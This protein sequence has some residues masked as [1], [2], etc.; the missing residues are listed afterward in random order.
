MKIKYIG[1]YIEQLSSGS[2]DDIVKFEIDDIKKNSELFRLLN[3]KDRDVLYLIFV[4]NK[5]QKAVQEIL[6]RSQPLLCYD[7]KRIKER[8]RFIAYLRSVF[9]ILIDFIE[10]DYEKLLAETEDLEK[11]TIDILISMFFTTSYTHTAKILGLP[12]IFVRYKFE[13]VLKVLK[14][15]KIWHIYEI[16]YVIYNNKN[17]IKR[18]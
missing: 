12:Q 2:E 4:S 5:K 1:D 18:L 15:K 6:G 17:K 11:N 13:Q 14:E 8:V 7:I 16:F 3:D 10:N 9:D